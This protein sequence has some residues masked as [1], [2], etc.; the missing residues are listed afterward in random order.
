MALKL[1]KPLTVIGATCF[2]LAGCS[3]GPYAA[4]S[5]SDLQ[6]AHHRCENADSLSPGGA[7]TCDNIRRECKSRAKDKGRTICF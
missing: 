7:I 3:D 2:L 1:L 6:D 4:Y 5:D